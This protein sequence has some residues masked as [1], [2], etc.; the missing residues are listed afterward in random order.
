MTNKNTKSQLDQLKEGMS[1]L[2]ATKA[3]VYYLHKSGQI[4]ET[5]TDEKIERLWKEAKAKKAKKEK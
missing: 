5:P 1:S 4:K 2:E 3:L